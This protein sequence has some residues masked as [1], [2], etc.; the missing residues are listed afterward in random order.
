[1]FCLEQKQC[2][3]LQSGDTKTTDPI[4]YHRGPLFIVGYDIVDT[5]LHGE[6][7]TSEICVILRAITN[8]YI[9]KLNNIFNLYFRQNE[10]ELDFIL[11]DLQ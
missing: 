9:L 3:R 4:Q 6:V 1:M 11:C 8:I 5:T 2:S 10:M 7:K